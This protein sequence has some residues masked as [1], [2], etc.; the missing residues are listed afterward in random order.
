[1]FILSFNSTE[2]MRLGLLPAKHVANLSSPTAMQKSTQASG[3]VTSTSLWKR[4]KR[5]F[6]KHHKP[7][8]YKDLAECTL[9]EE[10]L[11][12]V[13]LFYLFFFKTKLMASKITFSFNTP[14]VH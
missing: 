4:L 9:D 1:M 3:S 13:C 5:R 7:T 8:V 14:I 12:E 6:K 10:A 2:A 11:K